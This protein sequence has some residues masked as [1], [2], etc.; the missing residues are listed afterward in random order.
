MQKT[1]YLARTPT[2]YAELSLRAL[3]HHRRK[4]RAEDNEIRKRAF[5]SLCR[6]ERW[7]R[8][9]ESAVRLFADATVHAGAM[10]VVVASLADI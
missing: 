2:D 10:H 8:E 7:T 6:P 4:N 5:T 1:E 3:S 9:F